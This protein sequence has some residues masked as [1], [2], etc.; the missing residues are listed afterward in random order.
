[1]YA[2]PSLGRILVLGLIRLGGAAL[3]AAFGQFADAW[4]VLTHGE[5]KGSARH[6]EYP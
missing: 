4:Y 1:M 2:R 6:P 5:C 3:H